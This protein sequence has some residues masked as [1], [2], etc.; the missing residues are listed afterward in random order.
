M[1]VGEVPSGQ[2]WPAARLWAMSILE[3][4]DNLHDHLG[5]PG[6]WDPCKVELCALIGAAWCGRWR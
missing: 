5:I 2:D 6:R 4:R 1:C 3:D